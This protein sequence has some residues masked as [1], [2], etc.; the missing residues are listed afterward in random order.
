M[1]ISDLNIHKITK[2]RRDLPLS[3]LKIA[4]LIFYLQ[5]ESAIRCADSLICDISLSKFP[6]HSIRTFL[7]R[8]TER[9]IEN[10][11]IILVRLC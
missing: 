1:S 9:G 10:F 6:A 8:R 11:Y 2:R 5:I 3:S 7:A 4:A